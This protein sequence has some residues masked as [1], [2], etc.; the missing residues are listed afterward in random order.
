MFQDPG[1]LPPEPVALAKDDWWRSI[2]MPERFAGL[3]PYRPSE[4]LEMFK[5]LE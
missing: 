2:E 4:A 3:A 5:Q 1:P